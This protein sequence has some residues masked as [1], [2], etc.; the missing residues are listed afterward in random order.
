[1]EGQVVASEKRNRTGWRGGGA[2]GESGL[3]EM[4][5]DRGDG[6]GDGRHEKDT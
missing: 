2:D 4:T 5:R 3:E 6:E 1:V